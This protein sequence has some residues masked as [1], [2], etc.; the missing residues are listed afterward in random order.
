M[1]GRWGFIMYEMYEQVEYSSMCTTT[2]S[3][4]NFK[5]LIQQREGRMSEVKRD[6]VFTLACQTVR[7]MVMQW[8][9]AFKML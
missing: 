8:V 9:T 6:V 7:Y 3:S 4:S 1:F 2:G 5:D